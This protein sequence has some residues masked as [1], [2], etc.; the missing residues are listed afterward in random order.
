MFDND[1]TLNNPFQVDFEA[2]T[3]TE[4]ALPAVIELAAAIGWVPSP[5]RPSPPAW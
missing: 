4:H 5:H 3:A 2:R 1:S